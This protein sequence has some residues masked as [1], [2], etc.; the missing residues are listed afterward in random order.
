[1]SW[2]EFG[3]FGSV[4]FALYYFQQIK[5]T[6]KEKGFD[7]QPFT[8][9]TDDY[10]RY[11]QLIADTSDPKEK[12]KL[13]AMLNGLYMAVGGAVFFAFLLLSR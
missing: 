1:M 3:L 12:M 6:L 13:Q 2:L 10:R 5:M 8:G 4:I 9:W 11:R 7:I